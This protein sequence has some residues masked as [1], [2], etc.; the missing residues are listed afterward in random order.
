VGGHRDNE[1]PVANWPIEEMKPPM[2]LTK[3]MTFPAEADPLFPWIGGP[4]VF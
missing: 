2:P 1:E 4:A 3:Q